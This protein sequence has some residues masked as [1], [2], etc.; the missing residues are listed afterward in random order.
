[1]SN[2]HGRYHK[3]NTQKKKRKSLAVG[4]L[5]HE[6]RQA[7]RTRELNQARSGNTYLA[8]YYAL[9]ELGFQTY[10]AYL[11]SK[12]WYKIK[13]RAHL[14]KGR[15]CVLC[16]EETG[17]TIH[18]RRY[19][20]A[21]LS[22]ET[23]E[24]LDPICRICHKRIEHDDYGRK[25]TLQGANEKLRWLQYQRDQLAFGREHLAHFAGLRS[26]TEKPENTGNDIS[27][28]VPEGWQRES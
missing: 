3:K 12:L 21:D 24:F 17:N 27:G 2:N 9:R 26:Q 7:Q 10:E 28:L 5:I 11:Q 15:K 4:Q 1:M 8:R 16:L 13:Q 20:V 18:H 23:L 19:S 25:L 14:L 22:G 6:R